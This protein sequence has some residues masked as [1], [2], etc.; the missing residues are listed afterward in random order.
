[1]LSLWRRRPGC[2]VPRSEPGI[3]RPVV[4]V[5]R[6]SGSVLSAGVRT[7]PIPPS[8]NLCLISVEIPWCI[9]SALRQHGLS[10]HLPISPSSP[11]ISNCVSPSRAAAALAPLC[12]PR[13]LL[14]NR[15]GGAMVVESVSMGG[16]RG[17]GIDMWTTVWGGGS[18]IG[19]RVDGVYI[20]WVD[21]CFS[22]PATSKAATPDYGALCVMCYIKTNFIP[23]KPIEISSRCT[24]LC[25]RINT[26]VSVCTISFA[27]PVSSCDFLATKLSV[28][29]RCEAGMETTVWGS[30]I[31]GWDSGWVYIR[32]GVMKGF[33]DTR[34]ACRCGCIC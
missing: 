14:A 23:H 16:R 12:A 21:G 19:G 6:P 7:R 2:L 5:L 3:L 22:P 1:L 13:L 24:S 17:D 27:T 15:W 30:I 34:R 11:S 4:G 33:T 29:W 25:F 9:P 26:D 18:V 20:W 28:R 32:A 31:D 10:P 8:L